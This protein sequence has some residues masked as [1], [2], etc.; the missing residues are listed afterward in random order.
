MRVYRYGVY[1]SYHGVRPCRVALRALRTLRAL[2]FAERHPFYAA[3][4]PQGIVGGSVSPVVLYCLFDCPRTIPEI[5]FCV[6]S[7]VHEIIF[8]RNTSSVGKGSLAIEMSLRTALRSKRSAVLSLDLANHPRPSLA[9]QY[10][11][12]R[13]PFH[14]SPLLLGEVAVSAHIKP[15][16][17]CRTRRCPCRCKIPVRITHGF[18]WHIRDAVIRAK[19]HVRCT[20]VGHRSRSGPCC[21]AHLRIKYCRRCP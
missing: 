1:V 10:L 15:P 21:S 14:V 13:T 3:L 5:K 8:A 18:T 11:T 20:R 17:H 4:D 6:W 7:T 9:V 2:D 16:L 19:L 12:F